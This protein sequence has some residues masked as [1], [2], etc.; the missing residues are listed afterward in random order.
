MV[1]RSLSTL[2]VQVVC[3]RESDEVSSLRRR[4]VYGAGESTMAKHNAEIQRKNNI[5]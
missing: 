5:H 1:V 2:H 4:I 3:S